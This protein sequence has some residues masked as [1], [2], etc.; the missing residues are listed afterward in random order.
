MRSAK[1][2]DRLKLRLEQLGMTAAELSRKMN[3]SEAVISQYKSGKYEPKQDRLEAFAKTLDI[4]EAWLM[5]Y[6]TQEDAKMTLRE[7]LVQYRDEHKLSQRQFAEICGLSNGYISMLEKNF[8]P[9]T[10][11]PLTPSLPVLKKIATGMGI[12]LND[13]F[14]K[15]EDIPVELKYQF[16]D[17]PSSP[18]IFP[19]SVKK[20]PLLG[21]IACGEPIF[22]EADRESY[23]LSGTE[24][25]A[26]FCLKCEGDSMVN[27]RILDGDIVFIRKQEQVENGEI[28]AVSINDEVTLKRVVFF[29]EK[30]MII[31]KPEN[32]K[33]HD[34]VFT[35][36]ELNTIKILGKAVAFQSDVI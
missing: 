33:Y 36:E 4:S 26:D 25:A 6:D 30:D 9:S 34:M 5:G 29:P 1:F 21:S 11:E 19:I 17:I 23:I 2:S 14:L 7:L 27:A 22:K 16:G 28:A 35:D 3:L 32:S 8:N 15:I 18:N 13:L 20:Y 10:S 12:T 24:I 31:L